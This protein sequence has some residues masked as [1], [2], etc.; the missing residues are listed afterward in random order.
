MSAAAD[1]DV[2]ILDGFTALENIDIS[3]DSEITA[4]VS[5]AAV[6]DVCIY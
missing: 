4:T 5:S 6:S 2:Q 1:T 3:G